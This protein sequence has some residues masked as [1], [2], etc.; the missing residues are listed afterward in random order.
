MNANDLVESYVNDVAVQLPRRQRNDVA[1]ELRALIDE[2]LQEQAEVAG[3]TVDAA[4]A[5]E[6]LEAF[7][8]PADV[9]A[10]YRPELTVID[11]ADGRAFLR[12]TVIGLAIIWSLGLLQVFL[13]PGDAGG[14]LGKLGQWWVGTVVGSLWW[15][16]MLVVGFGLA[17]WTRRRWPQTSA[18]KPRAGDRVQGGR[19]AMSMALV[20]ILCGLYVLVEPRWVLDFFWGGRAAPAAYEALTY[21]EAFRQSPATWLLLLLMLL[22]I[23]IFATVIVSGR[24]SAT[25]RR[26]EDVQGVA[27]C[28]VLVWIVLDGPVFMAPASDRT[29]KFLLALI[30]AFTLIGW[31]V[32]LYRSVR[33]A[34]AP[35]R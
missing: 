29:T 23:P 10:R 27:I 8:R 11:P 21:T 26:V 30:V 19:V 9:A 33:P 14:F 32:R 35:G 17:T 24:W 1:F 5:I 6:F 34:P 13:Q 18:W 7:G 31:G 20:G 4:M 3:R 28:A 15:P 16:G 25:M 12:W 2:G 22:Y